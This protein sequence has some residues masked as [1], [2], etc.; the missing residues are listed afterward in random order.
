MSEKGRT[1]KAGWVLAGLCFFGLFA[2]I[3]T[4]PF[5]NFFGVSG[6]TLEVHFGTPVHR[7]VYTFFGPG[8]EELD[9]SQGLVDGFK[10]VSQEIVRSERSIDQRRYRLTGNLIT[11]LII[12]RNFPENGEV[13]I[14][15]EWFPLVFLPPEAKSALEEGRQK[16]RARWP[17]DFS[18]IVPTSGR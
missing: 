4:R 1:H 9:L 11:G 12:R 14:I 18:G 5:E 13:Y 17:E 3:I 8:Q 15:E 7:A 2:W 6:G 16:V 10:L